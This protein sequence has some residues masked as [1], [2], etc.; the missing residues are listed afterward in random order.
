MNKYDQI[1]PFR[2]PGILMLMLLF[3]IP[4]SC[5][6]STA[7]ACRCTSSKFVK[8]LESKNCRSIIINKIL[9]DTQ[10][11]EQKKYT[12]VAINLLR[13]SS[14]KPIVLGSASYL[15]ATL[16]TLEAIPLLI[17][18]LEEDYVIKSNERDYLLANPSSAL[19]KLGP[20]VVIP[21]IE[22]VDQFESSATHMVM[23]SII[24]QV[25]NG[26][27]ASVNYLASLDSDFILQH[28][29]EIKIL[30]D[31]IQKID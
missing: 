27:E 10:E 28:Q 9:N 22:K 23:A 21:L 17:D 25:L 3:L 30:T 6:S 20:P 31:L 4:E 8:K 26:K 2:N 1:I 13:E 16:K 18:N 19:I 15:L 12:A 24:Y 11:H 5:A 14:A 29:R 7:T